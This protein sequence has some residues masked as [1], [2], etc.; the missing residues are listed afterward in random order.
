[1]S[2]LIIGLLVI[3]LML[4]LLMGGTWVFCAMGLAGALGIFLHGA[5][6]GSALSRQMWGST[7]SFILTAI[8][9][10]VFMG[11]LMLRSGMSNSLYKGVTTWVGR[12]PGGLLHTNVVSCALFA[13]IS[14]SSVATAATMGTVA[15]PDQQARGYD[16]NLILGSLAASGTLG[17]LIPPSITMIIYGAWMQC[18]IARLFAGGVIPGII[19]STLF[20]L[21][22]GIKCYRNPRLASKAEASWKDRLLSIKDVWPGLLLIL[23]IMLAIFSGL[24]TPTETAAVAATGAVLLT[25]ILRKFSLRLLYDCA[26]N[27]I[28]TTTMIM[29]IYMAAKI[30]IM[31]LMYLGLVTTIPKYIASLD[32]SPVVVLLI[33]YL[34][35][36][37]LGCLMD[38]IS[39]LMVTLPFVAPLLLSLGIDVIW[40]GIVATVLIEIGLVTPPVGINLY[41]IM[42]VGKCSLQ[43]VTRGVL[44]FFL[45]LLF[46]VALLTVFPQVATWLPNTIF[47]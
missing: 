26:L 45:I 21:Y 42:S 35:Y 1:M 17:I 3:V 18:S 12:F 25:I 11:E 19:I 32:L 33:I 30:L 5:D 41:V 10:F 4:S 28:Y 13:A 31:S 9:L 7:N 34:L 15:I 8:P 6:L 40:F 46:A 2:N 47:G 39:L 38:G 24:M 37:V 23:F 43:E 20:M 14:G 36:L 27:T 22:I 29:I 16:R 44:P